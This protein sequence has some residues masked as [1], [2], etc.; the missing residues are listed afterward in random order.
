MSE[1]Y[2][3][4]S[5]Q[6][7]H[8][9]AV[10]YDA[11]KLSLMAERSLR[12]ALEREEIRIDLIQALV[13]MSLRQTG[14]GHK[15]SAFMYG[16]R[17]CLGVLSLGLNLKAT[18]KISQVSQSLTK[19]SE[20]LFADESR[21]MGRFALEFSGTSTYW[22]NVWLRKLVDPICCP[23]S[24]VPCRYLRLR[25]QMSSRHGLLLLH[26]HRPHLSPRQ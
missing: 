26:P 5:A 21:L 15:E 17:A 22:T 7:P 3:S 13:I 16:G 6:S 10:R 18:G 25:R 19:R 2:P 8:G 4:A 24:G 9:P 11:E 23:F 12:E 1:P 14:N 20:V